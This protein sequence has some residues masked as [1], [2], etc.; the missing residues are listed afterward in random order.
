MTAFT[1]TLFGKWNYRQREQPAG[2][3]LYIQTIP[4]C[5]E[6]LSDVNKRECDG[7]RIRKDMLIKG[8]NLS[9][10]GAKWY[11]KDCR[12]RFLSTKIKK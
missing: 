12:Y 5:P 2:V 8:N 9:R 7:E 11:R 4:G 6:W 10:N 3:S 1:T